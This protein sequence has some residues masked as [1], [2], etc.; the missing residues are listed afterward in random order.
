MHLF[1]FKVHSCRGI[2]VQ[3]VKD[4]GTY[5]C[6]VALFPEGHVLRHSVVVKEAMKCSSHV[7]ISY[8]SAPRVSFEPCCI[9]CGLYEELADDEEVK[10]TRKKFHMVR[11]ICTS[12][13][14]SGKN[15]ITRGPKN[16]SAK[17]PKL[18]T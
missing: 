17:R 12:C 6:G 8:Y 18:Q 3:H 9:H 13:K 16:F 2:E 15:L 10:E 11:P 14:N 1:C 4:E 5:T 7:E